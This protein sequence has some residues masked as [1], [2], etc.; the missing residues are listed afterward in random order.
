M[1]RD[2]QCRWGWGS[3]HGRGNFGG[4]YVGRLVVSN[5]GFMSLLCKN[6]CEAIDVPF[7]VDIG[8]GQRNVG[9]NGV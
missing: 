5:G 9:L 6:V 4:G 8:V 7:G 2:V 3:P 1:S